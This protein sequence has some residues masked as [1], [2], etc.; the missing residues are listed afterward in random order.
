[1]PV[2]NVILGKEPAWPDLAGKEVIHL[3]N[4]AP[5][6]QVASLEGGMAGGATSIAIRIDLPDGRIVIAETSLRLFVHGAKL[7]VARHG[8]PD[9]DTEPPMMFIG[10]FDAPPVWPGKCSPPCAETLRSYISSGQH[11]LCD[12]HNDPVPTL[13]TETQ[14]KLALLVLGSEGNKMEGP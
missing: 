6:I 10:K 8:D 5:P 4:D 13:W 9:P 11:W 1:M 12:T 7:L 3:G 14:R 2:L